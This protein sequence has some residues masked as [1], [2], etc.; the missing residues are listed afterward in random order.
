MADYLSLALCVVVYWVFSVFA[1]FI[2]V[3]FFKF[4]RRNK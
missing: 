1:V 4:V 2:L 3:S